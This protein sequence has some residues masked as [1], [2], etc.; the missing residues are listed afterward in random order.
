MTVLGGAIVL[1][2]VFVALAISLDS[3]GVGLTF[4]LKKVRVPLMSIA[5]ICGM[6]IMALILS[7]GLGTMILYIIPKNVANIISGTILI[8]IG[9]VYLFQGIIKLK[10][11]HLD[12][13]DAQ[14]EIFKFTIK[15]LK[16]VISI[17]EEPT[18]ADLDTSGEIDKKEAMLLGTALAIDAL[19]VGI[20]VSLGAIN[21]LLLLTIVAIVN[22]LLIKVGYCIGQQNKL[23][24]GKVTTLLPGIILITI[25]ITRYL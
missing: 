13:L 7:M 17:L 24:W 2:A 8:M 15:G 11:A 3:F 4:G 21:K 1:D 23:L 10:K 18:K 16:I 5:I 25:G 14:K 22:V 9:F 20:G 6:T 12:R 19:A